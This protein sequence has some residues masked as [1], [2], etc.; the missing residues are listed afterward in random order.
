MENNN[1]VKKARGRPKKINKTEE[2]IKL[3]ILERMI[4]HSLI[5]YWLS[6]NT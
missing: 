1:I 5:E 6:K 3:S 4:L 2:A